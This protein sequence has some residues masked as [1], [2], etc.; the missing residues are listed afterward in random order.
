MPSLSSKFDKGE[1]KGALVI[2]VTNESLELVDAWVAKMKPTYPIVVVQ[3]DGFDQA[4][5]VKGFP[6]A[7]VV[8][9]AGILTYAGYSPETAFSAAAKEATKG[10][11]YPKSLDKIRKSLKAGDL[12]KGYGDLLSTQAGGKVSE[13]DTEWFNNFKVW[14]EETVAT[15]V[16]LGAAELEGGRIYSAVTLVE[17]V[18]EADPPFPTTADAKALMEKMTAMPDFKK[19][20]KGGQ[21][22]E[23]A[24]ALAKEQAYTD[25]VKKYASI[26]KKYKD[27]LIGE[28]A[29]KAAAE[30]VEKGMPGYKSVCDPCRKGKKACEK[31]AESVRI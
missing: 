7:G 31:H 16:R 1:A 12:S 2:G 26:G 28:A 4:L 25:A 20:M 8:D 22:F 18:A 5:G 19:E 27:T 30:L 15:D 24:V 6:T 9:P 13:E 3:G 17:A 11:I 29:S 21:L 14:I 23:Q 10:S